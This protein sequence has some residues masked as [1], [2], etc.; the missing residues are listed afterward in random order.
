METQANNLNRSICFQVVASS[1]EGAKDLIKL[2]QNNPGATTVNQ[3]VLIGSGQSH[4]LLREEKESITVYFSDFESSVVGDVAESYRSAYLPMHRI[5]EGGKL[6]RTCDDVVAKQ[7]NSEIYFRINHFF[8]LNV[9][10][11]PQPV[12]I[13][14]SSVFC[15]KLA[16][17][18]PIQDGRQ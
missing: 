14:D 6:Y 18:H 12:V 4:F 1:L 16:S 17:S 10:E 7:L 15:S 13:G 9:N 11:T 8:L 5:A 3:G 2:C